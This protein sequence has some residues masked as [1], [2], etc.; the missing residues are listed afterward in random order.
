MAPAYALNLFMGEFERKAL[1][2]YTDKPHL[3]LRYID[4]IFMVWTHGQEKLDDF[5]KYLNNIH[6][7]IKFTSERSTTSIPF[8]DV[9]IQ[10][11]NGK[12]ETDLFCKPTDKHQYLLHSSVTHITQKSLS[13]T[14]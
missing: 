4:D 13:P 10:L 6:P 12:I 11:S 9:N 3:W 1:Q 2:N 14:A 5:I 8:L 7:T